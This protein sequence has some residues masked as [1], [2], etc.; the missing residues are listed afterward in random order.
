[1]R[2]ANWCIMTIPG[3]HLQVDDMVPS[4]R[5]RLRPD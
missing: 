5:R 1:M 2:L 3:R 4:E